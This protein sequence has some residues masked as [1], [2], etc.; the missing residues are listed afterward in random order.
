VGDEGEGVRVRR[1][2]AE[3]ESSGVVGYVT[4]GWFRCFSS[5]AAPFDVGRN[6]SPF[7]IFMTLEHAGDAKA[8]VRALVEQGYGRRAT[9]MVHGLRVRY[10]DVGAALRHMTG[11]PR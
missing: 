8:A 4:P 2:G 11:G 1:P 7:Q 10:G 3:S 9:A 5:N 6:Y